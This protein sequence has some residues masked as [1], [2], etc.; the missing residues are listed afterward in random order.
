MARVRLVGIV[1][2][3][4][5]TAVIPRLDLDI[6]D[7]EF[8]VLVGPSGCGKTT[9]LRMIAGLE[10]ASSGQILIGERDVTHLRPGL[11]NCAMVFQNYALYPHKTVREN[12]IYGLKVRK[13][14][15]AEI[16][17]LL[18]EAARILE[19]EPYLDRRPKQ[20]SGGQRQR[21]A[22]G[23]AIVRNPEVF[24]F[25]E[26]LSNL[27]AKLRIEMRAE[28]KNLHRRL[29]NTMVYVTHDQVEAMTLADRIVVMNQGRIEQIAAPIELYENPANT[30]VASFIGAP[31]MNF[32][33]AVV[34]AQGGGLAL[35]LQDG[36]ELPIPS[37]RGPRYRGLLD[38]RVTFGIRPEH[39]A[40][41]AQDGAV[42]RMTPRVV[43]PLGPHTLV[44]GEAAGGRLTPQIDAHY[45]VR[46]DEPLPITLRMERMHLFDAASG[47]AY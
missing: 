9:T 24:L 47:Q 40:A 27:D 36:A 45:P 5:N 46:L 13:T 42:I 11:R 14:P 10:E 22:I 17:R 44:L 1:K 21:V 4:G 16:E 34:V 19:L 28:I 12:I 33:P 7:K 6:A 2:S 23:R 8:I 32:L 43:E 18:A 3:F 30:F 31:S 35:R 41:G 37:E 38:Q 25:D 29:Q 15:S 20:L 26:P 39:M